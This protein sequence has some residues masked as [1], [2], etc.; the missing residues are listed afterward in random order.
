MELVIIVG[1]QGAGKSTFYRTFFVHSHVL[2]SKDLFRNNRRR[3]RR[4]A[5]LVDEALRAGC[6]VVVDNTNP[7][8]DDRR[9]LVEQGRAYSAVV[10]AYYFDVPFE[11]CFT[12]NRERQGK[13]RVPDVALYATA[14][15]LVA[16]TYAEGFDH[17]CHVTLPKPHT[18]A[19]TPIEK[20]SV[21]DG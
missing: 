12:R 17:L 20:A 19:V 4:Q 16:P 7:T 1:L 14:K 5:Y 6:S 11:I 13:A 18:F 10:A 8:V 3:A 15:K 9:A 21:P 2:V